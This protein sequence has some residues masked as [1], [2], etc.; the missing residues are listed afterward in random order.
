VKVQLFKAIIHDRLTSPDKSF[1]Q[2]TTG[3]EEKID[4]RLRA[5]YPNVFFEE[6]ED[7]R[8]LIFRSIDEAEDE[9]NNIGD[10]VKDQLIDLDV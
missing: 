5:I 6:Q 2:E 10:V 3:S 1:D 7:G 8:I 9:A 4:G